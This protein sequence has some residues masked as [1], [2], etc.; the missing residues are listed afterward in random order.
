MEFLPVAFLGVLHF[1][2]IVISRMHLALC[3]LRNARGLSD[4]V[5]IDPLFLPLSLA[6]SLQGRGDS[7]NEL[8]T[9]YT[10]AAA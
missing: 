2:I 7:H 9:Q 10:S 1:G 3:Y 6:R 8:T 4:R 5:T